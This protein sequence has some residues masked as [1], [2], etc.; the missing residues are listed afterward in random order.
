VKVRDLV[1]FLL[2]GVAVQTII[3]ASHR[4]LYKVARREWLIGESYLHLSPRGK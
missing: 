3:E 2:L 4:H 1:H